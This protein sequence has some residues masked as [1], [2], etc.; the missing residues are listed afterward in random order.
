VPVS[1]GSGT[2]WT[3]AGVARIAASGTR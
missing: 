2:Q 1:W 3:M